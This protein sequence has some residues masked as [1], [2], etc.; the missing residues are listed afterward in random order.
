MTFICFYFYTT[1]MYIFE[2]IIEKS[3]LLYMPAESFKFL[4]KH[5][6]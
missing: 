4:L 1:F 3:G 5:T 6:C 2:V